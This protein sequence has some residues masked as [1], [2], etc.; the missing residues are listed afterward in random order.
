M[1][2]K[3]YQSYQNSSEPYSKEA[4]DDFLTFC[5]HDNSDFIQRFHLIGRSLHAAVRTIRVSWILRT[6][7]SLKLDKILNFNNSHTKE[8]CLTMKF[9]K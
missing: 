7:Q 6:Q 8:K 5:W 2:I 9:W 4:G 3:G 1:T